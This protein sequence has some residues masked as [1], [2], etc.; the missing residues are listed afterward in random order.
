MNKKLEFWA[1]LSLIGC[2]LLLT[3]SLTVLPGIWA[4][5]GNVVAVIL[6]ILSGGL[7]GLSVE[8]KE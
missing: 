8:R 3:L 4:I 6:G 2:L 5:V 1:F 7:Y